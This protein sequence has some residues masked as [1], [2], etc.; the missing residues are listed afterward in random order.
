MIVDA[1]SGVRVIK[2][3][4]SVGVVAGSLTMSNIK[5]LI[6][7]DL[8]EILET[9]FGD[10]LI[11]DESG[12]LKAKDL[13]AR[14][15]RLYKYGLNRYGARVDFIVGDVVVI[16]FKVFEKWNNETDELCE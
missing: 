15:S 3:D 10:A 12:K 14:A 1:K 11:I 5:K 9:H 8:V 2:A 13:N 6:D 7:A 4:G 16:P